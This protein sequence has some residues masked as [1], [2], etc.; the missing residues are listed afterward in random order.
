MNL[1]F[2]IVFLS[3][4]GRSNWLAH[5]A[6]R[7]G[8]KVGLLDFTDFFKMGS[9]ADWQG[10]FPFFKTQEMDYQF[11]ELYTDQ[12]PCELLPFGQSFYIANKGMFCSSAE[13]KYQVLKS[14]DQIQNLDVEGD[15][16]GRE[17][18]MGLDFKKRFLPDVMSNLRSSEFRP[19]S[20]S[21]EHVLPHSLQAS[22]YDLQI[23]LRGFEQLMHWTQDQGLW[24]HSQT[25]PLELQRNEIGGWTL[26]SPRGRISTSKI[27]ASIT[28][29]E[30]QNLGFGQS[31]WSEPSELSHVWLRQRVKTST[32]STLESF[33]GH[34]VFVK[35]PARPLSMDN[36]AVLRKNT[37]Q[38]FDIWFKIPWELQNH[39]TES[40]NDV[41]K[42]LSESFHVFKEVT[43][44]ESFEEGDSEFNPWVQYN[45][46]TLK[47]DRPGV[48]YGGPEW[49]KALDLSSQYL[50]QKF[51]TDQLPMKSSI[52][53]VEIQA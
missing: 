21:V 52:T 6:Q 40:F 29:V 33:P 31:L 44:L 30:A 19:V 24:V 32:S 7:K 9:A 14:W 2:D 16:A 42:V 36:M 49:W 26:D 25:Q 37:D 46:Q 17:K 10:P 39:K 38:I 18:I 41:L 51:I 48:I 20:G 5:Q 3:I 8:Y 50:F 22:V 23:S 34:L 43:V 53:D 45:T 4:W 28:S 15:W 13:N 27:F 47:A 35:D 11:L 1:E 12:D